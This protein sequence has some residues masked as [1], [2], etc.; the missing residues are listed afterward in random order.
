MQTDSAASLLR[1][2]AHGMRAHTPAQRPSLVTPGGVRLPADGTGPHA[3]GTKYLLVVGGVCSSLGKGVTTSTI[4]ALLRGA[5][6]RVSAIKI[7][8]YINIDAGLMSP[9]EHG[10]VYVL[11][12]GG[13]VDLDLGNYERWMGLKLGRD[14]NITTGKVYNAL[15]TKERQGGYLGRTVQVVPHFT[16]WV[17]N[18]IK[19]VSATPADDSGEK[20][21]ICLIELGGTVGDLESAPF[22]E[23][24]R[25]LRHSLPPEDFS[26][27]LVTY[28]PNMGGQKTKPT[29]HSAKTLLSSGM[30]ADFLFCRCR[31]RLD[32]GARDKLSQLVGIKPK[33]IFSAHDVPNLYHVPVLFHAQN[34]VD[35]VL[36]KFQ[37]A[38]KRY[39]TPTI[40]SRNHFSGSMFPSA[41]V[42]AS[43]ATPVAAAAAASSLSSLPREGS[44]DSIHNSN[45]NN[46][47]SCPALP[48][49]GRNP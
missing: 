4:G 6:F 41:P 24:L 19:T 11:D 44:S 1:S 23:A 15:I 46:S 8:P 18:H 27:A 9:S 14:N 2:P 37:L 16:N 49:H 39:D 32:D 48:P 29:Q 47:G 30:I 22:I 34:V 33:Y 3:S 28:L 20:P 5:G 26:V 21:D 45:G 13:E 35:A 12:D 17:Q 10:E 36:H 31:D 38:P 40:P 42:A 43:V 25:Q 7:D